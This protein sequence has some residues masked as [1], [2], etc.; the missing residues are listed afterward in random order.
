MNTVIR[1]LFFAS[2]FAPAVLVSAFL[3][4]V[5]VGGTVVVFSWIFASTLTCLLPL[6]IIKAASRQS[7]QLQFVAKKIDSQDWLVVVFVV[8]Y[9]I[10]LVTKI[11]DLQVFVPIFLVASVILA[12]LDAI[13]CHPV[14]HLFRFRFYKIEA[15]NGMVY[16]LIARRRILSSSDLQTVKQL[17]PQ[18]LL[19]M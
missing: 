10:P 15:V 12:T 5:E 9:F 6:L 16:T 1:S 19:E 17:S 2:A 14:L 13:P 18:L 11:Q 8:T 3:Q 7:E 4:L